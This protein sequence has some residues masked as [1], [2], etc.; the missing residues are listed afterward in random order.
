[1]ADNSDIL[2]EMES[3]STFIEAA[4]RLTDWARELTGCRAAMLRFKEAD[5]REEGW[6]PAVVERGFDRRFLRDET[7]TGVEECLCGRVCRGK[8]D[9]RQPFFTAG[10]SFSCGKAQTLSRDSSFVSL[11][12]VRGRCITEGFESLGIYPIVVDGAPIGCLHLAD[13]AE[14]V[15]GR[16]EATLE[17]VCRRSGPT[18]LRFSAEERGASVIR[19]VEAALMPAEAPQIEGIELAVSFTSATDTAHLGG[20]F[21]DVIELD[22]DGTLLLVGDYSG[23]GIGAA[24]MAARARQILATAARPGRAVAD[25]LAHAEMLLRDILPEGRFVT[26]VACRLPRAGADL[27]AAVSGHP[28]PLLMQ[29]GGPVTE[30]ELPTNPP[31]GCFE[32]TAFSEGRGTIAPADTLLLYTDGIT[33]SRRG[34]RFFGLEGVAEVWRRMSGRGLDE[35]TAELCRSSAEFHDA[36]LSADDR[37]ALAVRMD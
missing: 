22:H 24:G 20:D 37:L 3:A 4:E 27:E 29:T 7:L 9:S 21:Y 16:H 12:N 28:P 23:K 1:M 35:F 2:R 13:E 33:E 36:A 30:L 15:F 14:D 8:L 32:D 11:E 31:L 25:I 5:S 6:I 18:L 19:A 34:G 10:G 26:V 17:E